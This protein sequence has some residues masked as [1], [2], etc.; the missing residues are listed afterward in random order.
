LEEG[1]ALG[2]GAVAEATEAESAAS[3]C[4]QLPCQWVNQAGIN[5][6]TVKFHR[7]CEEEEGEGI[8]DIATHVLPAAAALLQA[9]DGHLGVT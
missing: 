5:G 1:E 9:R 8:F 6:Q 3:I 2:I 7:P 4:T